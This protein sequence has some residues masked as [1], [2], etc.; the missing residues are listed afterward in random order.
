M[1]KTILCTL[2]PASLTSEIISRL[3]EL[4]VD[5]FRLN[6]SHTSV[7]EIKGLV[8]LVRSVSQVPICLD[9]QGAQIRTGT[10]IGKHVRLR[11]GDL[12]ELVSSP[13]QG[14]PGKVPL[15][16]STVIPQLVVGD[17]IS[18]D[19]DAVPL[20]VIE[21]GETC[22]AKVLGSGSIGSN[23]AISLDRTIA[24]AELTDVDHAA[25]ELGLELGIN[26]IALSFA[27]RRQDIEILRDLV[28]ED[29]NITAKIESRQGLENLAEILQVSDSILI[30]RGD[31]SREVPI[32]SIPFI[33][34]DIIKRANQAKVPVYVATNLLESM[35]VNPHPTRA[36]ANDVINTLLD[37]A[38]GLVLAAE[39]AIGDYPVECL[40][41]IRGLIQQ[42]EAHTDPSPLGIKPVPAL[43]WPLI[44]PH[45]DRLVKRVANASETFAIGS[46]PRFQVGEKVMMDAKQ[47]AQ[48]VFSPIE[49]FMGPDELESVLSR[50]QLLDGS[51]WPMP[52]LFQLP[53]GQEFDF[54]KGETLGLTT[55][56]N[57]NV[58]ALL[59]V[60]SCFTADL[61]D[62]TARWYGTTDVNHPGVAGLMNESNR[63]VAGKVDLLDEG[64]KHQQPYHVTPAQSRKVFAQRQWQKVVGFHTR[65]VPH[66]AHEYLQMAALQKHQCDGI[67]IH[68]VTGTK[69]PGDFSSEIIL[70]AYQLL[71]DQFYPPNVALLSGF[72]AYS[73]YAGPREAVFTA[74]CRKNFGCSHFI[75]GRDHTGVGDYY[76][77]EESQNLF[78]ELGD[79][80]IQPVFFDEI[81]YCDRCEVHVE[82]CQHGTDYRKIISGTRIRETLSQGQLLPQ[83][84]LR[85]PVSQLILEKL[86]NGSEVFT[87]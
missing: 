20:Q 82:S 76:A 79:I 25:I 27:N 71:I 26:N 4:K 35:V 64:L 83:W 58:A 11:S 24:L 50:Y 74:L 13:L 59:H 40:K 73:R 12:V 62:L 43:S 77:P 55:R 45:G 67:F 78:Q 6:L 39:V 61:K 2:G 65:N 70:N 10:F 34:K 53:D 3:D 49:G 15:Y 19:V 33:Q 52:I 63:F 54:I 72:E 81:Y 69:K 29:V 85:E 28:G 75:V 21:V 48:G 7:D 60:E 51:V 36:E 42:F 46:L 30:D 66:R 9:T 44:V 8:E 84:C 56:A 14:G 87:T 18:I 23:K 41:M 32:E 38:D 22:L 1:A 68:P 80:G 31:L 17:L 57:S 47:I 86:K 37:G 16:P 5:L